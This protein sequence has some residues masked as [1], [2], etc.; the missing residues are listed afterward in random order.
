M[1][2][3]DEAIERRDFVRMRWALPCAL[4]VEGRKYEGTV[5]DLSSGGLFVETHAELPEGA[6]A[7]VAFNVPDG[8]RFVLEASI[9][10][11]RAVLPRSL[12]GATPGGL[13]MRVIDPP[14]AFL[15]WVADR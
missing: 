15:T 14:R 12:D 2:Q 13:G 8:T 9:P 6:G 1:Q 10:R 11:Q 4:L 5:R 7:V 3:R